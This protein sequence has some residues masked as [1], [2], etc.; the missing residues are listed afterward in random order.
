MSSTLE[1][2]NIKQA[3]SNGVEIYAE[4]ASTPLLPPRSGSDSGSSTY[5][6]KKWC[7]IRRSTCLLTLYI[8]AYI[9]YIIAGSVVFAVLETIGQD[10]DFE[11]LERTAAKVSSLKKA[12]LTKCPDIESE[13]DS[14]VESSS[15]LVTSRS[16]SHWPFFGRPYDEVDEDFQKWSPGSTILFTVS[17]LT[18]VGYGHIA[19][20]T[21]T[22]RLFCV[23]YATVGV[24]F[25]LVF[26]SACVQRLLGP[27][28]SMLEFLCRSSLSSKT[29][30]LS[31]RIIH[32]A[33][34][35]A[36]FISFFVLLPTAIFWGLEPEWSLASSFYFVFISL[37]TIGLGDLVPGE[38]AEDLT[39][40]KDLYQICIAIYLLLSLVFLSLTLS[41]FYDI[42]QFNLGLHLNKHRDIYLDEEQNS[43]SD[44][45]HKKT[46]FKPKRFLCFKR[47]PS[48]AS[49][50]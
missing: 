11:D 18:T 41:V 27:T 26:L 39:V 36:M 8:I 14:I 45:G 13:L 1:S 16:L 3:S 30:Q 48:N 17:V 33:I 28:E 21:F 32:C 50:E 25:T 44:S 47:Q 20:E 23:A 22:G 29:S 49:N 19:P 40:N 37:T 12:L 43:S 31:I 7:G 46:D 4:S 24:P 34:M 6:T 9:I 10:D 5:K 2:D 35:F 15:G 38:M 42:P